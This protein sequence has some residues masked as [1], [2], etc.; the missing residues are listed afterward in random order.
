MSGAT[1]TVIACEEPAF[2]VKL[3]GEMVTPDGRLPAET[4]IGPVKLLLVADTVTGKDWPAAMLMAT[5]EAASWRL[6]GAGA[7]AGV[8]VTPM[9]K[10]LKRTRARGEALGIASESDVARQFVVNVL[11]ATNHHP[12]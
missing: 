5:G 7:A 4:E 3:L 2:S 9:P 10:L 12:N 1:E 6:G 11:G 8:T